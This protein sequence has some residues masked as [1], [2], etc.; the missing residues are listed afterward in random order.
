MLGCSSGRGGGPALVAPGVHQGAVAEPFV[1]RFALEPGRRLLYRRSDAASGA[2]APAEI[3]WVER[4]R[5]GSLV[6]GVDDP[7]AQAAGRAEM[8]ADLVFPITRDPVGSEPVRTHRTVVVGDLRLAVDE[9][10]RIT[11]RTGREARVVFRRRTA[12]VDSGEGAPAPLTQQLGHAV[13]DTAALRYTRIEFTETRA[14][15]FG[16]GSGS[17]VW[18]LDAGA[19]ESPNRPPLAA[20]LAAHDAAS[21]IDDVV[22][23]LADPTATPGALGFVLQAHPAALWTKVIDRPEAGARFVQDTRVTD[24]LSRGAHDEVVALLRAR[25]SEVGFAHA[26]IAQTADERLRPEL[27]RLAAGRGSV[28]TD[29]RLTLQALDLAAQPRI[30]GWR[31]F[32]RL[33]ARLQAVWA[34]L[35]ARAAADPSPLVP[36]LLALA[37]SPS[38]PA[39]VGEVCGG[40]VRAAGLLDAADDRRVWRQWWA[41]AGATPWADRLVQAAREAPPERRE[42]AAASLAQ[43]PDQAAA[44]DLLAARLRDASAPTRFAAARALARWRDPRAAAVLVRALR[45]P[46]R[47]ADA[48][49]ALGFLADTT[50]GFDPT[51]PDRSA[52][53]ERWEQWLGSR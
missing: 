29:A 21:E 2:D 28:A 44:R 40:V 19:S 1:L 16:G 23:A 42:A 26:V 9:E 20:Y 14:E 17:T 34:R 51:A 33:P 38:T 53:L 46:A 35:S 45:D 47:A 27:R 30:E 3:H 37:S 8:P 39:A 22:A 7:E 4:R 15:A 18:E 48:L 5:D 52:A 25:W 32:A 49:D 12:V 6:L 41:D 50:L 13:F 31:P 24:D 10:L 36:V 43:G 11:G